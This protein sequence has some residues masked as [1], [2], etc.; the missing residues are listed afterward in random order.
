MVVVTSRGG[1][2]SLGS[3]AHSYDLQEPYLRTAFGFAGITDI[4]FINAQPMDALG[5]DVQARK[6][7]QANLAAVKLVEKF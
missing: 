6:I 2:Y 5:P 4:I 3:P 7:E 1:D